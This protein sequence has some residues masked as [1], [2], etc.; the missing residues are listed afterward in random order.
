[1]AVGENA[2]DARVV[3][4]GV[5][6]ADVA[7]TEVVLGGVVVEGEEVGEGLAEEGEGLGEGRPFLGA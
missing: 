5:G 7:A 6:L 4:A 1:V 3:L 2:T